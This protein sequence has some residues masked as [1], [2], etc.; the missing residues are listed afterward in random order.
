MVE[1]YNL[2][3]NAQVSAV[4][5]AKDGVKAKDLDAICRN[6]FKKHKPE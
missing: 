4:K 5:A 1:M 3:L 2:V 6:Y